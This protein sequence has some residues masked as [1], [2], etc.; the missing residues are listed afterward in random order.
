M[1]LHPNTLVNTLLHVLGVIVV[2]LILYNVGMV[3]LYGFY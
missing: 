3:L 1:N 2:V